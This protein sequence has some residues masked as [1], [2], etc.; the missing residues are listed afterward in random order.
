[1]LNKVIETIESNNMINKG[2]KVIVG[3]S[4]GPDSMCLLHLLMTLKGYYSLEII[5]SH[6]NH[7]LRGNESDEDEKYVEKFCLENNIKFTSIKE[8]VHKIS[9]E[10]NISC[11]SAGRDLRYEFFNKIK[12]EYKA[13]KIAVAHNLNDQAETVLMRMIRGAAL[14]GLGGIKP[15]RDK[16]YIRPLLF[17]TR[18]EIE[19]YC[20]KN[21]LNPRIDHTNFQNIYARNKIRLELIPYIENNF[22]KDIINTLSRL[23]ENLRLDSDYMDHEAEKKYKTYCTNKEDRVIISKEGFL[24]HEAI[25]SRVIRKAFLCL[26]GH[27]N[28]FEKKHIYQVIELQKSSTGKSTMLPNQLIAFNNY[29]S[30]NIYPKGNSPLVPIQC[31]E[32]KLN[33]GEN[34][35]NELGIRICIDEMESKQASYENLE[36]VKY[37]DMDKVQGDILLRFRKNGDKFSPLGI[38]GHKKLKDVFIDMKVPR[39]ERDRIPLICFGDE[40]AW[41]VGYKISNKF[42]IDKS[43]KRV[44]RMKLEREEKR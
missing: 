37:F 42:K 26:L 5:A 10:R 23:S 34:L 17:C 39:E 19:E 30:I 41:I 11:E 21:R 22:N 38:S 9:V 29:G 36:D 2:D 40:I 15:V 7:G 33:V 32:Y 31:K 16:L 24:E 44:L 12:V 14:E 3:V 1:M 35:I 28:N 4:G 43:T 27:L 13:D 6:I 20:E 8:D 18:N 25:V